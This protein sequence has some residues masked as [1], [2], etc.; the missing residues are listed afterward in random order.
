MSHST[1]DSQM[2]RFDE[3]GLRRYR[4]RDAILAVALVSSLLLVVEGAGIRRAGEQM[5]PGVGGDAVR[6]IGA[7][8]GW[9]A[10]RLPLGD[11]V[12]DATAWLSPDEELVSGAGF[13]DRA[14]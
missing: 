8:A 5:G 9:V 6:V 10:D 11:L 14:G 12:H 7:P 13:D 3:H 1:D 2:N 4:A